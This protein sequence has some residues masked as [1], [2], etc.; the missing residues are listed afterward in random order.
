MELYHKIKTVFKRNPIDKTLLMGEYSEPEFEYLKRNFW[1]FT[2]KVD[3]MNIRIISYPEGTVEFRGRT[4]NAQ[5]PA[6]LV[7]RL[8][9]LFPK[10]GKLHEQFPNGACLYGE[11]YGAGIQKGGGNYFST[12]EFVMFDI[13][14][15]GWWLKRRDM[16]DIADILKIR[17]VPIVSLGTLA[18]SVEI[19]K[20]GFASRWGNFQAE[21]IVARPEV[22]LFSRNGDRIIA[23][24]KCKDFE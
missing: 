21:G 16:T 6:K 4:D 10:N 8:I 14:I 20:G 22:E 15:G 9:E 23:K 2:E 7:K 11:G 24:L 1:V 18:N 5:I 19:V 17:V 12:Q 3:G 13:K